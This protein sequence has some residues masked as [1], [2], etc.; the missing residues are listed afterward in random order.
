MSAALF[1]V[2]VTR[3][4]L[5]S[6]AS[7]RLSMHALQVRHPFHC[8]SL[9]MIPVGLYFT[10]NLVSY[11]QEPPCA[12]RNKSEQYLQLNYC[13]NTTTR[14]YLSIRQKNELLLYISDSIL[15][16]DLETSNTNLELKYLLERSNMQTPR[17]SLYS[18]RQRGCEASSSLCRNYASKVAQNKSLGTNISRI[19]SQLA[20]MS[21]HELLDCR[22]DGRGRRRCPERETINLGNF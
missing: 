11:S 13:Y 16:I 6:S 8:R 19:H 7:I 10:G 9:I 4:D 12:S 18:D 22:L 3:Q 17:K 20:S 14:S 15:S 2:L 21:R 5:A 1:W